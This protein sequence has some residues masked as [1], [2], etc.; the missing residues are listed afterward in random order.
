MS[1][2]DR[3]GQKVGAF[4]LYVENLFT[5]L[6][7]GMRA[8]LIAIFVIIKVV[9][10][11]L[12]A[13]VAW[14]QSWLL[15]EELKE[16]TSEITEKAYQALSQ[17]GDI[18]ISDAVG[19]LDTR[20]T[21]DI[22]R[23]STDTA[24][25]V[26]D[27]LYTRDND[28]LL[29]ADLPPNA[30]IYKEFVDNL[31]G[32]IVVQSEYVLSADG[33]SWVIADPAP[34]PTQVQSSLEENDRFH[35]RPPEQFN[36]ES[37]PLYLEMTFVDLT[38]QERIK[39]TTSE[40]MSR[41]L[42]DVSKRENTFCKAETYFEH[43][44]DLQPGEIWVGDVIGEYVGSKI[45]D[46]YTPATAEKAGIPYE[47]ENSAWAG[48]ENPHGKR[49][50]GIVR[51][52]TPVV[53][54]GRIIGYVT[55]ALDHDHL[56]EF[57]SHLMPTEERYTEI[58]DASKGN[59]AFI[60]DY[61]GRSIVHPRHFSI[62]G[63][64]PETGDPQVPWLE[65]R[66][67]YEWQNSGLPY[68]EFIQSVPTFVNQS[69]SNKPSLELKAEGLV[70]LDCRYLNFAP[71][72][73]GWFDLTQDGGSGSFLILWSGLWKLNTAAAIQYY[74]GQYGE[75]RRGFGFVAIGA[76][77]TD[78]HGPARATQKVL[79]TLIGTTDVE[80]RDIAAETY[81]SIGRNLL[82]TATSLSV[83]TAVMAALVILVAIWMA[84]VFTRSITRLINGISRFRSGE[85]HFRFNSPIKD[86]IG[87]LADSF[88]EMADSLVESVSGTLT[89]TDLDLKVLYM[90]DDSL[91]KSGRRLDEVLGAD[92]RAITMF[93]LNSA[94]DP[95]AALKEGREADAFFH[96]PS[97]RYFKGHAAYLYDKE[98]Q[99]IGY[100]ITSNDVTEI[101]L[102]QK[103][104]EEQR[105]LLE[106]T[107]TASPDIIWYKDGED[108]YLAVNPRFASL[109]GKTTEQVRGQTSAD[110]LPASLRSFADNDRQAAAHGAPLY[111]EEQ[112]TFTDGHTEVVD[113]VRR[114]IFDSTGKLTGL[115]GV[116]RDVTQRVA[117]ESELR[118]TQIELREAVEDA[119]RANKSK[120]EFLA[121]MSHEIRT[122]MNAIIGMTN[123][124]KR[125]LEGSLADK[126][127]VINHVQQIEISSQHLLA[128]LN[129]VLDISKIEA[130][131]IELVE[132]SFNLRKL[133]DSIAL[134]I[135]PRCLEKNIKFDIEVLNLEAEQFISDPLRLRQVLINLLG[136]AVKFTPE[137]G[138]IGL[139]IT[140]TARS[141]GKSLVHFLI[142]DSGIGMSE[143]VQ[144]NLFKPFEQG[145]HHITRH[146]GGTGLGLSISRNI[147]NMLGSD[148]TV[149]S[150]EGQGSEFAF[151]VWLTEDSVKLDE[152][153]HSDDVSVL[154][155]KR[156][157]L[158][159]DVAINR[160]IVTEQLAATGVEMTVDEA[161]DGKEAVEMFAKSPIGYYD[162]IFMDVQMPHMDGHEATR[163]IR[164]M[165]RS[166]AKSVAIIAMTANAFKEDVERAIESG[167][168]AH[169]AKP[170]EH[171][172]LMSILLR[173][174][175]GHGLRN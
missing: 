101:A 13:I 148:I 121:R 163:R 17:T 131:K 69:N 108:R 49:F 6:G 1:E 162:I 36:Y 61:K 149:K 116:A 95:L 47:P 38:G 58:P 152:I 80:L 102:E 51:W 46:V 175:S 48:K 158:V 100:I 64:D 2:K 22:E 144:S 92:Y 63:Y 65:D 10:L 172:K 103:R 137:K 129:D 70:G 112:L 165:D 146:Y 7:L 122:P 104:I 110:V 171:E 68:A 106:T 37:R 5:R 4:R 138:N 33:N 20:A 27:F 135:R 28:V 88:D 124:T 32:K 42:K 143:A 147:V 130:G 169:L 81:K 166:D 82:E 19:A 25:R 127:E 56:M 3:Q 91:D 141:N 126:S 14:R 125:K 67:Y 164:A 167:M 155:G 15:G 134:I 31:R 16:R 18:A 109:V 41:E 145:S 105:A 170:L 89:I 75:S 23:M 35:Y 132:E 98:G 153:V 119:N 73:T 97:Q 53:E 123:I 72:C 99:A 96:E 21:D 117:V 120:S 151:T 24:R 118:E 62:T 83:S 107:F 150:T 93:P 43:L 30:D 128:L 140:V 142:K 11:I 78:F 161:E 90:N 87:A 54:N 55:L 57:T 44:K 79:D 173:S 115:L 168:N 74:T 52:A 156:A 12:L 113:A 50:K 34:N 133:V 114:P 29:A 59:Y 157:L 26:A 84:S 136:N 77:L 40:L 139:V 8:K 66:I 154:K 9:P 86:E 76:G 60:W 45:I 39:V 160:I 85:R 159:D 111:T 71:Q 174:A 94:F